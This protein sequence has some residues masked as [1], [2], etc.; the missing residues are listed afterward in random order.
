MFTVTLSK[1]KGK[2]KMKKN[3]HPLACQHSGRWHLSLRFCK[4]HL[5][6]WNK[7]WTQ[8]QYPILGSKQRLNLQGQNESLAGKG[9]PSSN[10]HLGAQLPAPA[11]RTSQRVL[12]TIRRSSAASRPLSF[13]CTDQP[14]P[15]TVHMK[16]CG[17]TTN[18]REMGMVTPNGCCFPQSNPPLL[19]FPKP[20][21][22]FA[23]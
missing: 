21:S 18:S 23:H 14:W 5:Q 7:S 11:V 15:K 3:S 6:T 10:A 22:Q 8:N 12:E 9:G 19:I 17:D 4:P 2:G 20:L 16:R 13:L 1:G